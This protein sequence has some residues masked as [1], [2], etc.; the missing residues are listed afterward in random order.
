MDVRQ[1]SFLFFRET[2]EWSPVQRHSNP[3]P[4]TPH[5][6]KFLVELCILMIFSVVRGFL[7]FILDRNEEN[8]RDNGVNLC[9]SF[10]AKFDIC[11]Y[12][13]I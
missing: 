2:M 11:C 3:H 5:L 13:C 10:F 1:V 7:N 8:I 6:M 12:T 4:Y 9:K